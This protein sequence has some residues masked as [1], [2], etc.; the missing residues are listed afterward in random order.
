MK[1]TTVFDREQV[2]PCPSCGTPRVGID[3]DDDYDVVPGRIVEPTCACADCRQRQSQY[4]THRWQARDVS[5]P[6]LSACPACGHALTWDRKVRS[7]SRYDD[8]ELIFTSSCQDGQRR[9]EALPGCPK[10]REAHSW[11]GVGLTAGE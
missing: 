7:V 10:C 2:E 3:R 11:F 4:V 6:D 1:T 8:G 5:D 9:F